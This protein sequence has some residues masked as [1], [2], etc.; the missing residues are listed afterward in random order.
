MR[1]EN[2]EENV[3]EALAAMILNLDRANGGSRHLE[4]IEFFHSFAL[5]SQ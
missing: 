3:A 1:A 2:N 4:R 5:P